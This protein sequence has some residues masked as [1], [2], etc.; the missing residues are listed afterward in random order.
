MSAKVPAVRAYP[1]DQTRQFTGQGSRRFRYRLRI[2]Q[3]RHPE[4]HFAD[5]VQRDPENSAP[6]Q[7]AFL[8]RALQGSLNAI[9]R[10]DPVVQLV[11][12]LCD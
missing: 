12:T 4:Q 9:H 2:L 3:I 8:A 7:F 6:P 11:H 5:V 1:I 10:I